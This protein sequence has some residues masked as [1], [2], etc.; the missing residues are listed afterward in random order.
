MP[1]ESLARRLLDELS[2]SQRLFLEHAQPVQAVRQGMDAVYRAVLAA[3]DGLDE[4]Q[5]LWSPS[6]GEWSMAEVLEHMA[7]HDR[8]VA[9][10][11]RRGAVHYVEHGL[12]HALQIWALRRDRP[13]PAAP[14]EPPSGTLD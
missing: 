5:L 12:E 3:L 6:A 7:E 10:I 11:E 8:H 14:G 1:D 13:A 9:E 4:G 2:V